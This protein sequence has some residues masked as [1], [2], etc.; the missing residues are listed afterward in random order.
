[1]GDVC[2]GLHHPAWHQESPC[3][4]FVSE[5]AGRP[6]CDVFAIGDD[7]TGKLGFLRDEV[8][9]LPSTSE[10]S[11]TQIKQELHKQFRTGDI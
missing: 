7:R 11:A 2:T 8:V 5:C 6:L 10:M 9:D 3:R 4:D 1:M